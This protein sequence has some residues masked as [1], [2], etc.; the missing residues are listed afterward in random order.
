MTNATKRVLKW[1]VPVDDQPHEIGC[2]KV[3]HVAC[4]S[5]PELV[6]V[7]TEEHAPGKPEQTREVQVYGT[8][9]QV[10]MFAE[11]VG[12]V[13]TAGGA[14]V[15]HVYELPPVV[16]PIVGSGAPMKRRGGLNGDPIR[17][18]FP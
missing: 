10:P 15:W 4:Q 11:H 6:M 12:S 3:V 7:W 1:V 17:E 13:V 5:G 8:G 18:T 16:G 2:G 14:L 9:H